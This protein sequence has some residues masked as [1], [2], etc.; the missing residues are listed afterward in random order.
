MHKFTDQVTIGVEPRSSD[1]QSLHTYFPSMECLAAT[2]MFF[3][4][5]VVSCAI[6]K[7]QLFADPE[8]ADFLYIFLV[9]EVGL[10]ATFKNNDFEVFLIYTSVSKLRRVGA[11]DVSSQHQGKRKKYLC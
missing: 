6:V 7:D 4:F 10:G 1:S 2:C 9:L 8:A 5:Q 3:S 11:Q